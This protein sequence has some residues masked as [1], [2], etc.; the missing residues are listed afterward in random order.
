[1]IRLRFMLEDTLTGVDTLSEIPSEF[2]P[3]LRSALE[4]L[5]NTVGERLASVHKF[6]REDALTRAATALGTLRAA[7]NAVVPE[8]DPHYEA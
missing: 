2:G 6:D 7:I 8:G 4:E 5:N 3:A 1:V